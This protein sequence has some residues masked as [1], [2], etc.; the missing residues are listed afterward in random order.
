[1]QYVDATNDPEM[2]LKYNIPNLSYS[3]LM[4]GVTKQVQFCKKKND[5]S[6]SIIFKTG[7]P[8]KDVYL[9]EVTLS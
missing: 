7:L 3:P 8:K 4:Y 9:L 1:M 5:S 6:I 2:L